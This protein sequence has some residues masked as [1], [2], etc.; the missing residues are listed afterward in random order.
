MKK[1]FAAA[2]IAILV[3]G[4]QTHNSS[5]DDPIDTYKYDASKSFALNVLSAANISGDLKDLEIPEDEYKPYSKITSFQTTAALTSYYRAPIPG[6]SGPSTAMI[7][8]ALIA[9]KPQ[10]K[11]AESAI[12]AWMPKSGTIGKTV[13][14][15]ADVL[16]EAVAKTATSLDFDYEV[17]ASK[18]GKSGV[19]IA[20]Y[21]DGVCARKGTTPQF[22]WIAFSINEATETVSPDF[23]G[24]SPTYFFDPST[25]RT[26]FYFNKYN[27]SLNEFNFITTLS[28]NLPSWTFI[29]LAPNTVS[30]ESNANVKVPLLLNDGNIHS[31]TKVSRQ[32]K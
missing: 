26:N 32:N 25:A 12:I 13:D 27:D 6:V 15:F 18:K 8:A 7:G 28:S 11:S 20:L 14:N 24:G 31:F 10:P 5:P 23:V 30:L 21:K 2:I 22:C 17:L 3:S 1:S 19:S 29:Y 4:C 16:I 9:F